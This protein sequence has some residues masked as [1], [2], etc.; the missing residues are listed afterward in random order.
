MRQ[1][2]QYPQLAVLVFLLVLLASLFRELAWPVYFILAVLIGFL[3]GQNT[4]VS[5]LANMVTAIVRMRGRPG[6][7]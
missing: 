1:R 7:P 5:H 6:E 4:V 3:F 2:K